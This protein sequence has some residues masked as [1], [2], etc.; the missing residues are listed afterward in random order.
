MRA[1][2][3]LLCWVFFSC[4]ILYHLSSTPPASSWTNPSPGGTLFFVLA[5]VNEAF[6]A[7]IITLS[8]SVF[9][10][11]PTKRTCC[12]SHILMMLEPS[13]ITVCGG[14]CVGTQGTTRQTAETVLR[15]WR[16]SLL[17]PP[18]MSV[19]EIFNLPWCGRVRAQS[20]EQYTGH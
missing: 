10:S 1:K 14:P 8:L 11:I 3:F 16:G 9:L 4:V 19:L 5:F 7:R 6:V 2:I 17:L 12:L 15:R 20:L 18:P 13:E